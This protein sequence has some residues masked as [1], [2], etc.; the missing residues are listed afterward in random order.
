MNPLSQQKAFHTAIVISPPTH[1]W[2]AIQSIRKF[3]DSAYERWMPHINMSFPFVLEQDFDIAFDLLQNEL[4]D[5]DAFPIH[6]KTLGYFTHSKDCVLWVNPEVE[7]NELNK[8]EEKILKV[9]P[10]CDDLKKKSEDGF[11][12]HLT[13]GHFDEKY[14]IKKQTISQEKWV[15]FAFIVNELYMIFRKDNESPFYVMKTIKLKST[16]ISNGTNS[17]SINKEMKNFEK[18]FYQT[19]CF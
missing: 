5:F 7:N 6:M 17:E 12:P 1:H 8:L 18:N 11:H 19:N 3:Y 13:L 4:K 10:F 14:I 15:P 9:F 2:E 16:E